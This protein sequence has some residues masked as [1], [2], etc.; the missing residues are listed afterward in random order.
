MVGQLKCLSPRAVHYGV[1]HAASHKK[2]IKYITKA[3]GAGL[4][5]GT[6]AFPEAAPFTIPA[7]AINRAIAKR[8]AASG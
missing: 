4:Q 2:I 1:L 6:A 8:F 5:I 7:M 3:I